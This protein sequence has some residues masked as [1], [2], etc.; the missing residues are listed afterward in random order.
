MYPWFE[1][2]TTHITILLRSE[3]EIYPP[4]QTSS[5]PIK[6]LI[7]YVPKFDNW[8]I[9]EQK[10][11]PNVNAMTFVTGAN[12]TKSAIPPTDQVWKINIDGNWQETEDV[13]VISGN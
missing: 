13:K 1:N 3:K 2:S 8:R 7:W 6:F 10:N 11:F 9:A 4:L 5:Y 12:K